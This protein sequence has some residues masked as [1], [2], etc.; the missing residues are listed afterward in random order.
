MN[1]S[2]N[3]HEVTDI[4]IGDTRHNVSAAETYA[5]RTIT[6]RTKSGDF[7]VT[8]FSVHVDEDDERSLLQVKF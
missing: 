4:L 8:L 3:V 1:F 6:I 2:F 5:T 7:E